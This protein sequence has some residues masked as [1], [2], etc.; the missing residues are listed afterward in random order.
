M[1]VYW[2]GTL[3]HSY[4]FDTSGHSQSDMGWVERHEAVTA[5]GATSTVEFADATPDHSAC[6]ANL[7]EVSLR[8]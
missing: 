6:G 7:D 4:K 2:D 1:D 8:G 3:V 5:T